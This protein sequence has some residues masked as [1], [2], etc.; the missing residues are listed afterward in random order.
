[1]HFRQRLSDFLILLK[2]ETSSWEKGAAV[3]WF[4]SPFFGSTITLAFFRIGLLLVAG[5]AELHKV[6]KTCSL[7]VSSSSRAP[8]A[9]AVFEAKGWRIVVSSDGLE[10]KG[11]SWLSLSFEALWV[12]GG[13]APA[14][15]TFQPSRPG[16]VFIV[17]VSCASSSRA[18]SRA[19][20]RLYA[21]Q[22]FSRQNA[23][24]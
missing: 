3:I 12:G 9:F 14:L 21:V 6:C 1:M 23:Q 13:Q 8:T 5:S 11:L 17:C 19:N 7:V 16:S 24:N 15:L 10:G 20:H 4:P 18:P 2:C 22:D